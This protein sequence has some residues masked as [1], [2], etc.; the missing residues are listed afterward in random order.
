MIAWFAALFTGRVPDGMHGFIAGF[1]RYSARV[2]AYGSILADP[3]PPFGGGGEYPVDVEIDP[4]APQGRLGVFFRFF[5]ALP[6]LIVANLL[7]NLLG[8]VAIG[9]WF[10]ALFTGR[11]RRACRRSASSACA[12]RPARTPMSCS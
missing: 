1:S 6:C 12:S 5:L 11:V 8:L 2:T 10:V 4:P 7:Q 9:S 3:F